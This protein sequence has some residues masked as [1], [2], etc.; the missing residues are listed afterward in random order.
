M[1]SRLA[2]SRSASL[3]CDWLLDGTEA[4]WSQCPTS[5]IATHQRE[6]RKGETARVCVMCVYVWHKNVMDCASACVCVCVSIFDVNMKGKQR[7]TVDLT[8]E[9]IAV[10]MEGWMD[11]WK[12]GWMDESIHR[13]RAASTQSRIITFRTQALVHFIKYRVEK[14][15]RIDRGC[16]NERLNRT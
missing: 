1:L 8:D 9:R 5:R 6:M 16:F 10:G 11:G 15:I 12:D 7:L 2:S 4:A 14:S 3:S 13:C